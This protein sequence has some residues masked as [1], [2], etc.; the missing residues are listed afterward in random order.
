[1]PLPRSQIF[2]QPDYLPPSR[3]LSK[4]PSLTVLFVLT[5]NSYI[6]GTD[7]L[8]T[9]LWSSSPLNSFHF[10]YSWGKFLMDVFV[11]IRN[12]EFAT[13]KCTLPV[14]SQW[15]SEF[16]VYKN[17]RDCIWELPS[18]GRNPFLGLIVVIRLILPGT[19][20]SLPMRPVYFIIGHLW[21]SDEL[22]C[23]SSKSLTSTSKIRAFPKLQWLASHML[24]F[25]FL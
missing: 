21:L 10:F 1:M 14:P 12:R 17:L 6:W 16:R 7:F 25:K 13:S 5:C 24:S 23:P 19:G 15:T 11:S 3:P 2:S 4:V 22:F 18:Q 9:P 8:S 20:S